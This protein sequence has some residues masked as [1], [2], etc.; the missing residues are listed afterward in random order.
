MRDAAAATAPGRAILAAAGAEVEYLTLVDPLTMAPLTELDRDAL[1][2]LAARIGVVRLID[3]L[4][5]PVHPRPT[6]H[7]AATLLEARTA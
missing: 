2:V 5:V 3:N 7:A 1:A 6:D 4:A